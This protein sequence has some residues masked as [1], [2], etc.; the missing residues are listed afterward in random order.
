MSPNN[1][2]S[3]KEISAKGYKEAIETYLSLAI[4]RASDAWS[5]S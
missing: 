5:T 1:N 4:S 3:E 2:L